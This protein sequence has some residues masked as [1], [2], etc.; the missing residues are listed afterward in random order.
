[1]PI[2]TL[3]HQRIHKQKTSGFSLVELMVGMTVGLIVLFIVG[4][5]F[6]SVLD[7]STY[8]LRAARLN[9]EL[10]VAMNFITDD[11]RRAGYWSE[12]AENALRPLSQ[13]EDN[14]FT[15]RVAASGD[16]RDIHILASGTCIMFSYDADA[17]FAGDQRV[18]G[19]R[20]TGNVLEMLMD[21]TTATNNCATGD[22]QPITDNSAVTV[23]TLSF[24]VT[25]SR[26]YNTTQ[27]IGWTV[28]A[29]G[30]TIPACE[31]EAN[32]VAVD[33]DEDYENPAEGD[34]MV[35]SRLIN[36]TLTGTH[37]ADPNNRIS[38]QE[39]VKIRNNRIF[40]APA[41]PVL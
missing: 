41:P 20:L 24:D 33:N 36:I 40:L 25:G 6:L 32:A 28:T 5:I 13:Q 7:G 4:T 18:F 39:T 21:G 3:Q 23:T 19:Y 37:A 29:A 16:I 31:N 10:R 34:L 12:A 1:M 22:W 38:L 15:N 9:Q 8:T 26:C 30:A 35:E 14:P 27:E 2:L 17:N 11:L